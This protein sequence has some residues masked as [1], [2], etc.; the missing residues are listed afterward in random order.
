V[1]PSF[2]VVVALIAMFSPS[3]DKSEDIVFLISGI[4][5]DIFGLSRQTVQSRFTIL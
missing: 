3:V 4:K 5:E 1:K 2:S